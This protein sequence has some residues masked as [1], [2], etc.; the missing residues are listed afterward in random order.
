MLRPFE[1]VVAVGHLAEFTVAHHANP[2]AHLPDHGK[3]VAD[4]QHRE[5]EF[6]L[7]ILQKI[8]NLRLDGDVQ[9]RGGFV[10]DQEARPCR[11]RARD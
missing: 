4:E 7:Q 2:V 9:R 10:A 11:K 3:V 8:E 1:E 5:A 6:F